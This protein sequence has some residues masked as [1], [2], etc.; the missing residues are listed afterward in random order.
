MNIGITIALIIVLAVLNWEWWVKR[1]LLRPW[2]EVRAVLDIYRIR[3]QQR[4]ILRKSIA[5]IEKLK[6][7]ILAIGGVQIMGPNDVHLLAGWSFDCSNGTPVNHVD[8][9]GVP[10]YCGYSARELIEIYKR[11]DEYIERP[12]R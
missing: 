7:K 5:E 12:R 6:A 2:A 3:R 4:R 9:Q 11:R 8:Q 10:H 1:Q